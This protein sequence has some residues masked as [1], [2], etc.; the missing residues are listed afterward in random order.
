MIDGFE[1][2]TVSKSDQTR[3]KPTI[4]IRDLPRWEA[5]RKRLEG[6]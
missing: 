6:R 5:Q 3:V 2:A 1:Q 4:P